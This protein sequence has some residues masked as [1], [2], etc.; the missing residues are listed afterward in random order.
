MKPPAQK[1]LTGHEVLHSSGEINYLAPYPYSSNLEE[2]G[3]PLRSRLSVL[4]RISIDA[5]MATWKAHPESQIIIPGETTFEGD[6]TATT[7]LMIVRAKQTTDIPDSALVPL[8]KL[9]N[10]RGLDNTYL[11]TERLAQF[12]EAEPGNTIVIAL[13]YHLLRVM[14]TARAYGLDAGFVTAESILQARGI[15]AYDRYFPYIEQIGN[16]G[17][18]AERNLRFVNQIDRR[19][20]LFNLLTQIGGPRIVDVVEVDGKLQ[21][22]NTFARRKLKELR[23]LPSIS[24]SSSSIK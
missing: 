24:S 10:S 15:H 2:G 3:I 8:Y 4:S 19:G 22:E 13:N 17:I 14:Q 12:L 16:Q 7:D 1:V 23:D 6:F 11:Q 21:V 18:R 9:P 20:R 5:A